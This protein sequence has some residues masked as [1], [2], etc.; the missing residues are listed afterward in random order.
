MFNLL[1][2]I[3]LVAPIV[4]ASALGA[5]RALWIAW[6]VALLL[7]PVWMTI[8]IGA[9]RLDLRTGAAIGCL[10]GF[11]VRPEPAAPTRMTSADW[12]MAALIFVQVLSENA[13]G[14]MGTF[15]NPDILRQWLLPYL[16][17]RMFLGST[18]DLARATRPMSK[19]LLIVCLFAM[20]EAVTK[21]HPVNKI[22]G[23]TYGLLEQG[24]G[25]RMGLKRSQVMTDHPIF[26]GMM[27]VLL[28]P[29]AIEASRRAGTGDGPRWWKAAPWLVA[30]AL[31]G[32]VSRGPQLSA[33]FTGLAAIFFRNP[34][35]RV[36]MLVVAFVA[37]AGGYAVKEIL[38]EQLEQVAGETEE[39]TRILIIDGEEELYSGTRH[40]VL[41]FKVYKDAL[42]RAGF[43]GWGQQMLG[44]QLEESIA[45]RFGSID[46]HYV[47][48]FLQRGYSGVVPFVILQ[49]CTLAQLGR[50][51]WIGRGARANMAGSLFGAML[52][53]DVGFFSVWFSPDFGAVWLFNCGLSAKLATLMPD[54]AIRPEVA[55]HNA[56]AAA[57]LF[58]F[59]LYAGAAPV[60]N[61]PVEAT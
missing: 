54:T 47:M 40:R 31:I 42:D 11:L 32:S 34:R 52:A 49:F 35:W 33:I 55:S 56:M 18:V 17:G 3:T 20:F 53:V 27:M 16:M 12:I 60:R 22:L 38:V 19:I 37:G 15:T 21:F 13:V 41:L 26:F 29:W 7:L 6:P 24:E 43:F 45:E 10:I 44:I 30:G 23:R 46:S 51:A 39:N 8:S 57:G 4:L 28:Q 50:A 59:R 36:T 48:F 58:P 14:M 2:V 1:F 25:Y 9:M 5:R 61:R